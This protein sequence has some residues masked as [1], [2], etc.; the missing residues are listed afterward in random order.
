MKLLQVTPAQL[1]QS[2]SYVTAKVVGINR[3]GR[4]GGGRPPECSRTNILDAHQVPSTPTCFNCAYGG[5]SCEGCHR[6]VQIR[7]NKTK[8]QYT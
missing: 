8:Q 6:T 3:V 1:S 5:L 2:M 7:F 4:I